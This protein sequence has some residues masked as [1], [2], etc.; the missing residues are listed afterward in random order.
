MDGN[1]LYGGLL[2]KC[3][4]FR[5]TN[6]PLTSYRHFVHRLI[7]ITTP[8]KDTDKRKDITSDVYQLC[9][10]DSNTSTSVNCNK[11]RNLEIFR[12]Q[13][14]T[15]P[16]LALAQ[17]ENPTFSA[18][19]ALTTKANVEVQ[20]TTQQLP[21]FCSD[22]SYNLY[23]NHGSEEL[24]LYPDGPCHD[25]GVA[26]VTIHVN[27][28]PCPDAFTL[29]NKHCI[30]EERLQAHE[31]SCTIGA[32]DNYITK[33]VG[34]NL[35]VGAVY[36]NDS[37]QGLILDGSCPLDYCKIEGLGLKM[38]DLDKQCDNNR[39]GKLC[40][41][42][43]ANLSL[44]LGTSRC[45]MCSNTH[46]TLLLPFAAAG[47]ALVIFLS[48]FRLTITTGMLNS[49][50]LYANIVHI[51][52]KLFFPVDATKILTVFLAW[53]N[54][55]LGFET[56]FYNGMDEY[57]QTWLQFAFPIYVWILISLIILSSRYSIT[58]SKLIGHNPIAVLATLLLMSYTKI[59][60]IIIEVYSYAG[61]E[62]PGNKTVSVWL[63]D[64]NVSYLQSK[65]LFLTV[66]TSL[67]LV[68]LFLPYTILLLIGSKLY[69]YTG[70]KYFRW[71][72]RLKPLLDSYYAPYKIHTRYWSGFLL[73]VRWIL[74]IV[75]SI[76][77]LKRSDMSLLAI[78]IT[79][80]AIGFGSGYIYS[81]KV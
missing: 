44:L 64:A 54:L 2:S 57:A 34:S 19:T 9:I 16:L 50:I 53:M 61:L 21:D 66:V 22:L 23:S 80:T 65:H 70:R 3:V 1:F 63:K 46:L 58:V 11:S 47:V 69:R 73:L 25:I 71:L 62:Y 81:G 77:S 45:A 74:Y 12:G 48:M 67:L 78:T 60:K 28:L 5:F 79:F 39:S 38:G 7:N 41:A 18:I 75:F 17:G 27:F 32:K 24:V 10:C 29:S 31:A 35:W 37:Y 30:C 49:L 43:A 13:E 52:R 56:C 14:F 36:S 40:G 26:K 15:L 55:D 42:C 76:N 72:N 33:K 8:A 20:Q 6:V 68:F 4:Y 51:N 59:L